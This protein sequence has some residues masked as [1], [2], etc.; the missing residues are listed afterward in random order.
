MRAVV[1]ALLLLPAARALAPPDTALAPPPSSL[2]VHLPFCRRRCHYCDFPVVVAGDGPRRSRDVERY[3]TFVARELDAQA[4]APAPLDTCYFGGGTPSLVE[5]RVLE[6]LINT[7]VS[8]HGLAAGAEVTMECDPGTFTEATLAEYLRAG[9]T[10]VS[11]GVQALDDAVLRGAGRAHT[12]ADALDAVRIVRAAAP[13]H[14]WSLDLI[15]GLPGSSPES[16]RRTLDEA[17]ALGPDHVSCYDLQI[18]AG[19][20]FGAWYGGSDGAPPPPNRPARPSEADAADAYRAA[21]E[22]LQR[23]G[24]DHYEISSYARTGRSRHNANYWTPSASWLALGLGATSSAGGGRFTRP[25]DLKEYEAWVADGAAVAYAGGG[26]L[27][28]DVLTALRTREGLDVDRVAASYGAAARDA[29]LA[30]AGD[31]VQLGLAVVERGSLRLTDP[32]G[33][34]FSNVVLTAIF[35]E[36]DSKGVVT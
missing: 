17:V 29:V 1:G 22:V 5:P 10:R 34:L 33:F 11:L 35:A 2:Y 9:V 6:G 36:L 4:A 18:E 30:G 32:D 31:G 13:A 7:I 23:A 24:Y 26:D 20:A 21:S 28:D 16:W 8:K 27:L 14:G 15:G 12:R 25:R 19:T 3:A